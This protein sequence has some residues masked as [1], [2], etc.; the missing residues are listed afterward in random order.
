MQN[1]PL[2]NHV[3]VLRLLDTSGYLFSTAV[4][5]SGSGSVLFFDYAVV[6]EEATPPSP[7]PSPVPQSPSPSPVPQSPSP[8]PVPPSPYV[9]LLW[10]QRSNLICLSSHQRLGPALGGVLGGTAAL[11]IAVLAVI[12]FRRRAHKGDP[13]DPDNP[14]IV[15]D[16]QEQEQLVIAAGLHHDPAPVLSLGEGSSARATA[17]YQLHAEHE[18]PLTATPFTTLTSHLLPHHDSSTPPTPQS[19]AE[20]DSQILARMY[21]LGMPVPEI[22]RIAEVMRAQNQTARGAGSDALAE[23]ENEPRPPA[24]GL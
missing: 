11:A 12:Y 8:S 13:E 16:K 7:S 15:S 6:N 2:G 5:S 20:A 22:A 14:I 4:G 24:Y 18:V 10:F 19:R 9:Y 23:G 3:L 1:L 21:T 17:T